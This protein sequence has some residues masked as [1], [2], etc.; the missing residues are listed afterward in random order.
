MALNQHFTASA[1]V[2]APT[3]SESSRQLGNTV[4]SLGS[5]LA[6]IGAASCC[7]LPFAFATIG[8][9]GAWI[10]NLTAL[11]PYQP[12]FVI[13]TVVLLAGGFYLVYRK[14]KAACVE[15]SYCSRPSAQ[16]T[17]RITLWLA[18][19]LFAATVAF[20]YAAPLL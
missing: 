10:G 8:V 20:P 11:G 19:V 6:S 17:A 2:D 18:T 14:P 16:R 13:A 12:Y 7:V 1:E 15:G 3:A 5:V 9:S 4:V